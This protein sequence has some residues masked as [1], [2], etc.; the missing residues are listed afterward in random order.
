MKIALIGATGFVGTALLKELTDRGHE[1][2][3]IARH[4]EKLV[5]KGAL[6]HPVAADILNVEQ[7]A[8]VLKGQ[9]A[10]VSAYNPGWDDLKIYEHYITGARAIAE[11]ARKS[12]VKRLIV[13]GGA[14]SLEVAPGVQL[15]DTPQFPA[16][17]KAGASA[18]RDYLREISQETELEWTYFS[19]AILMNHEH[20]GVRRGHYRLGLDSPVFDEAGKSILSVEDLAVVIADE[21]ENAKH[22][23]RR[24]TAG[25]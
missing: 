23:R 9:D 3:A 24:F 21:V 5:V 4:P 10:V 6:V 19:P 14:G 11:A 12:G 1:V 8:R 15:I 18:A 13:I 22:I 25:Y 2:T 17:F 16:E 7:V 20:S